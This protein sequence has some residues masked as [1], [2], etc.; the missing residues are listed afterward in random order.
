M[1]DLF[2]SR[3]KAVRL[4][5]GAMLMLVAIMLVVTL[6]PG[7][8]TPTVNE[9]LLAE[10]GD[11]ALTVRE[12]QLRLTAEMRNQ[13][14]PREMAEI[15]V[16]QYVNQMILERAVAFEAARRGFEVTDEEVAKAIHSFIPYLFEN[17]KLVSREAYA[18]LLAQQNLSINEFETGLR[19]QMLAG[20]LQNMVLEGMVVAPEELER[21]FKAANEKI[22]VEYVAIS[23][24]SFR[25]KVAVSPAEIQNY[26]NANR[27]SYQVGEK[28]SFEVVALDQPALA[29]A[30]T[31]SDDELRKI[32]NQ[33]QD[34]FRTPDR[35]RVRHILLTT[36]ETPAA[37]VPKVEE[38]A[39]DLL[40]QLKGG[41]NFA[42]LAKTHSQDPGSAA[43]GGD[44]DWVTRGQT[45]PN[46]EK[47]AF[48]LKPNELSDVIKTEYGFHIIQILEKQE[49]QLRPF[50]AVKA[51]LLAEQKSQIVFDRMQ[52]V[53]DQMRA[54]LA[55]NPADAAGVAS[56]FNV[57]HVKVER[58]AD[59]D[60]IPGLGAGGE[61]RTL[62]LSAA[63]GEVTSLA[64][65]S[66]DTLA[67]AVVTDVLP[68]RPAELAEVENQ[69]RDHLMSRKMAEAVEQKAKEADYL[70]KGGTKDMKEIA[71]ALG[72]EVKL[73]GEVTRVETI[74]GLGAAAYIGAAFSEPVGAVFGPVSFGDRSAV[75]RVA[76]KIP[77]DMA[78][79]STER[80][81][82]LEQV[83]TQRARARKE[84]FEDGILAQLTKEGRVTIY[85][86]AI[87]RMIGSYAAN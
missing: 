13:S 5:L 71:R 29:A 26:F 16:Q 6:I 81:R 33:E 80:D 59:G 19:R 60:S 53:G 85:Q 58:F 1:F 64:Q 2:R 54:A 57:R 3:T 62:I 61:L 36:T 32:Y 82:L 31:I 10:V 55:A 73:S 20:R 45:V 86:D 47:T 83:K 69:I 70:V 27:A 38:K 84:L 39:K 37:D 51:E 11:D 22:K 4:M 23:P 56:K 44:L 25:G 40:K 46:F 72:G 66:Q 35:V 21:E 9:Q 8:G 49:A 63:K 76:A 48:S 50:E 68:A 65:V 52:T 30:T 34:R 43:K 75:V 41:A 18:Q 15:Y 87:S 24:E 79:F 7:F 78:K 77:A 14:F 74:D 17:G 42:E 12:V 67:A 28:R